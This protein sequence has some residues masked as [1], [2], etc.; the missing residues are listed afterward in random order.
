MKKVIMSLAVLLCLTPSLHAQD[1]GQYWV[2]GSI[3]F[4]TSKIKDGGSRLTDYNI[5]PEFGYGFSD[6]WGAGIRLGY[7]HNEF[8]GQAGKNK[9]DGFAVAPFA[10]YS[11]LKGGVGNLFLDGGA[12][13]TYSKNKTTS[14]KT[15]ELEVGIRP[16][17]SVNL[18]RNLALTGRFGF[19]GYQYEKM[20]STKSNTFACNFDLDQ[21]Q[22]GVNYRF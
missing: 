2:G 16:G 22:L 21:I 1:A 6:R 11:F 8:Q 20:G 9:T 4:E 5:M 18:S 7:V 10:R 14:T 15:H 3:G 17:V 13:Y 19:I 12:G